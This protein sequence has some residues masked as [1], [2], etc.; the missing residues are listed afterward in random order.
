[1][2]VFNL[3]ERGFTFYLIIF[4]AILI[5]VERFHKLISVFY[6]SPPGP[7]GFPVLGHLPLLGNNPS[8]TLMAMS[9]TYGD[10][11]LIR[12]GSWPTL[13]LNNKEVIREA[14]VDFSR[15]ILGSTRIFHSESFK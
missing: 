11:F 10:V 7:W 2:D 5:V 15:H 12:M 9:K 14:M 13:I 8:K 1:M 6:F 3:D 4:A